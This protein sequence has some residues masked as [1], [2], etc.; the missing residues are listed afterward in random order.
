MNFLFKSLLVASFFASLNAH[1][2]M[3]LV[4]MSNWYSK[5]TVSTDGVKPLVYAGSAY[6][7]G[8]CDLNGLTPCNSCQG[9]VTG[10]KLAACNTQ[11]VYP[12]L[13]IKISLSTTVT[14]IPNV[15]DARVYVGTSTGNVTTATITMNGSTLNVEFPWSDLCAKA[16]PTGGAACTASFSTSLSIGF[17]TS[18]N[19]SGELSEKYDMQVV[20]SYIDAANS[21]TATYQLCKDGEAAPT[22]PDASFPYG[23]CYME[24]KRGDGKIYI[25]PTR[26]AAS[27]PTFKS[28]VTYGGIRVF[29][30]PTTDY[31]SIT[32]AS[33]SVDFDLVG[34][35]AELG[36]NRIQDLENGT[37]Y[38][39]ILANKDIT[40][41]IFYFTPT[42]LST[43]DEKKQ[44][45]IPDK[46]IGLLDDKNCFI[47][48]AAFGSEMAPKVKILRAFRDKF[49]L[50]YSWGQSFVRTY[51]KI[52]PP[53]ANYIAEHESLR[54]AT[55]A[56]LWPVIAWSQLTLALGFPMA[57]L[58]SFLSCFVI[59]VGLFQ[60]RQRFSRG[61]LNA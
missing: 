31:T 4:G 55:R 45:A 16:A 58:V 11:S 34:T 6:A 15:S 9:N 37:Q 56:A 23:V 2:T 43:V 3:T 29:Y 1:A 46:V 19:T 14:P 27:Y 53:I 22:P 54:T 33:P 51:Y 10:S 5:L 50:P 44:C 18:G 17:I 42:N 32:N 59:G 8:T 13:K 21:N 61:K 30:A 12:G 41:N 25:D 38:C 35:T 24:A 49:L 39:V 40:G 52:S 20:Y 47:A 60:V 57:L 7:S 48:T 28:P 36:E 26:Y